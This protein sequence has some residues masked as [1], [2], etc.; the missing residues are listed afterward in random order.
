MRYYTKNKM[1]QFTLFQK[2][3]SEIILCIKTKYLLVNVNIF[4]LKRSG[5]TCMGL[6]SSRF[7]YSR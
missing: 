7:S 6:L 3:L 5:F 2:W 1:S 4:K